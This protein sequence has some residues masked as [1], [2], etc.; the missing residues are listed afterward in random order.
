MEFVA[1]FTL[2]NEALDVQFDVSEV[3]NFD[4]LFKIDGGAV[5]GSIGGNIQNQIDLIELIDS[6]VTEVEGQGVISAER[7]GNT[8]V[9]TSTTY[10]HEQ[11]IASNVWEINHNLNKKPSIV[12]VDTAGTVFYGQIEYTNNNTCTVYINGA[13]K[14][15][16]YLN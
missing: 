8:V 9:I 11:G 5:W 12:L 2:N 6:K 10:V 4:A 1:N 15:K 13:T 7:T 3:E 16:A 14:G